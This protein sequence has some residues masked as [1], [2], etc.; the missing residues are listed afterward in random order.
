MRELMAKDASVWDI[1]G[2]YP[3]M[4]SRLVS[5]LKDMARQGL[6]VPTQKGLS[7][8]RQG[9]AEAAREGLVPR[10]PTTCRACSGRGLEAGQFREVLREFR[11]IAAKRPRAVP[12]FDQ[13]YVDE[14]NALARCLLLY[15]RG[16]LEGSRVFLLGDDDLTGICLA[17][18][19]L[20]RAVTVV[21]ID[22]RLI[23][24]TG[25][26][27]A[28]RGLPIEVSLYDARQALPSRM[29]GTHQVFITDPVE[30]LPGI[31]LFLSR[32]VQALEG[33]GTAGYFGL[34]HL[35]ASRV[36]W[37]AI[38]RM[39]LEMN[40]VVTDAL[41]FFNRYLLEDDEYFTGLLI[42]GIGEGK[43]RPGRPWYNSTFFRVEAY[44]PPRPLHRG[45]SD[46]GEELYMDDD[47]RQFGQI[48]P[49]LPGKGDGQ[50]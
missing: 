5:D 10:R 11:S 18:T 17:L 22:R 28:R 9:M 50:A 23:D 44:G 47:L 46:M 41:P 12:E 15:E 39:L 14:E 34:T 32:C 26:V 29:D 43:D 2:S 24:F 48:E 36:K 7:L 4:L 3:S 1:A 13:G 20:P 35:E 38:Q 49:G 21:E 30:T 31:G 37:A 40:L 45:D 8:T 6:T 42:K 27:A 19:G 33:P 25:D 16:D